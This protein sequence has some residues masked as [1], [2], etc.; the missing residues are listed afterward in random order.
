LERLAFDEDTEYSAV[1]ASIHLARYAVAAPFCRGARV[2]DIAS[3]EGYGARFLA[4]QDALEV[5][6]VEVDAP[7]VER[8]NARFGG[9]AV[10]FVCADAAE[11]DALLEPDAFDL[12]VSLETIE[13]VKDPE[14]FLRAL[15][16]L[17]RADATL[18]IS[19]PNDH[20]YFPDPADKNPYHLRKYTFDEFRQMAEAILGTAEQWLL[21][22]PV[23]GFGTVPHDPASETASPR[24]STQF[25]M[26][27]YAA[28]ST[29]FA[30]PAED[31]FQLETASSSY[32]VGIWG[33]SGP[34]RSKVCG[35]TVIYPLSMD[36][37]HPAFQLSECR[38][39]ASRNQQ[40]EAHV[41]SLEAALATVR[42]LK[43]YLPGWLIRTIKRV[44][45]R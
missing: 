32:F 12:V 7:T 31:A 11:V 36:A 30:V 43:A 42:R 34:V 15:H 38:Q 37:F 39:L 45:A 33:A 16:R 17:A 25:R 1:E 22:G 10:S 8:A 44:L 35:S 28:L 3:G 13:H 20:W 5:V 27:A 23:M 4:N 41:A 24:D 6:G 2:L 14:G 29:A 40:L 21:G 19:C 18:I 26:N 9:G